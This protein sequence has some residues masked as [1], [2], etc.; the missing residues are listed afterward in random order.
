LVWVFVN[1]VG[2]M[3]NSKDLV[4]VSLNNQ[5]VSL[6][7]ESNILYILGKFGVHYI[8]MHDTLFLKAI[9]YCLFYNQLSQRNNLIKQLLLSKFQGSAVGSFIELKITGLGFR[10]KLIEIGYLL[11]NLGY[12]HAFAMKI[13]QGI[14]ILLNK[15]RILLFSLDLLLLGNFVNKLI[16]LRRMDVYKGKGVKILLK[17]IKLKEGKKQKI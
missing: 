8:S 12:S 11:L 5:L 7:L 9:E 2:K 4:K 3:K 14:N 16:K 17:N 1:Q 15:D 6:K 10:V 13:P